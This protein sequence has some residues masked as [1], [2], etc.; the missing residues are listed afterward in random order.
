MTQI[1]SYIKSYKA[2]DR[3]PLIINFT[4]DLP[5]GLP[6]NYDLLRDWF[7][8]EAIRVVDKM[9]DHL[10][11]GLTDAIFAEM[12]HRKASLWIVSYKD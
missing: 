6:E 9:Y 8:Q 3:K 4:K 11:G 7:H 10:P 1:N 12:A 5:E 2:K